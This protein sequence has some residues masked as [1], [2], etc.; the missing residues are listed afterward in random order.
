V[1]LRGHAHRRGHVPWCYWDFGMIERAS[2]YVV[3]VIDKRECQPRET[4]FVMYPGEAG[5]VF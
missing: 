3:R 2:G 4:T 5:L 1:V